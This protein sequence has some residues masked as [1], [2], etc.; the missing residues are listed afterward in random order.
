MARKHWNK[1]FVKLHAFNLF[2]VIED[3]SASSQNSHLEGG[4]TF[5]DGKLTVPTS[6]RYLIYANLFYRNNGRLF[7]QAGDNVLSMI[8][9]ASD[10]PSGGSGGGTNSAS[11][12][13]TLNAGDSIHLETYTTSQL[14]MGSQGSY[15][16][17]C[18][19]GAYMI[20][21]LTVVLRQIDVLVTTAG[22]N[23]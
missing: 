17:Y 15:N 13:F 21:L 22:I 2:L 11:G 12:V 18:Y 1:L 20:W 7:I 23:W 4:M 5:Q 10:T 14:L 9:P 8:A 6:G 3:F 16:Y 19:F